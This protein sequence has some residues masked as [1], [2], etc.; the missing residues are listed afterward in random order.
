MDGISIQA[1][2]KANDDFKLYVERYARKE[3]I[4][5]VEALTHKM[6]EEVAEYYLKIS[7]ESK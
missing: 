2:Y 1:L 5:V 3:G 4:L 7:M 6:V